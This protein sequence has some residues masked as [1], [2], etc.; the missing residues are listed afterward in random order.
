MKQ[1]LLSQLETGSELL[2][3]EHRQVLQLIGRAIE[4]SRNG[5]TEADLIAELDDIRD[6]LSSHFESEESIMS[7]VDAHHADNHRKQHSYVMFSLE[8]HISAIASAN[9]KQHATY[10][11]LVSLYYWYVVH[12]KTVDKELVALVGSRVTA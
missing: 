11:I 10:E 5:A 2:D 7:G 1:D 3:L 6:S 4:T 12:I 8:A 9:D